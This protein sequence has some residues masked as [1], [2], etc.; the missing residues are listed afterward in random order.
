MDMASDLRRVDDWSNTF[1]RILHMVDDSEET[2]LLDKIMSELRGDIDYLKKELVAVGDSIDTL[3]AEVAQVIIQRLAELTKR[4][5][6]NRR[7]TCKAAIL[8]Y[9]PP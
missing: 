7:I 1:K 8:P 6:S 4:Q 5:R 2:K 9:L 3:L